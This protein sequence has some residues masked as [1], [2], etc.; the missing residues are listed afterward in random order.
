MEQELLKSII[1]WGPGMVIAAMVLFGLYRL[2][3][4]IGMKLVECSKKQAVAIEGLT[5]AIEESTSRDNNEHRE[6]IIMLK[7][8]SEKIERVCNGG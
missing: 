4:G 5:R 7:V 3:N 1:Q 2:A 6:I 8:I